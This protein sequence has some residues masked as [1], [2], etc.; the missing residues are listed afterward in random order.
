MKVLVI[1]AGSSSIKYELF[2]MDRQIRL[3]QG[4]VGRIGE[5]ESSLSYKAEGKEYKSNVSSLDYTKGLRLAM[6]MLVHPDHGVMDGLEEISAVGHRVVH[7]GEK[8]GESVLITQDVE[9]AIEE[10][11]SLAPLHNPPNLTCIRACKSLLPD[12]PHVAVFDTACHQS[13]PEHAYIYAIPYEL[14]EAH[15]IRRYGFHGTS[16]RYVANRAAKMLDQPLYSLKM[17]TCHLGNG[18][19]VTAVRDGRSVDTS[20]GF[21]PL[22]GLVMGTRSGDIDPAIV[23]YL[24]EDLNMKIAEIDDLL[25][26][27]SGLLGISGIS[28]DV[29]DISK[30]AAQGNKRAELALKVFS[31]RVRKYIG[32]Y[33]AAMGGIDVVVFTGGIGENA[34]NVREMICGE[35]G[36]L[37]LKLNFEK[38]RVASSREEVISQ[39]DSKVKVLVIRTDE[40]WLIAQ[41]TFDLV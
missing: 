28:N 5:E 16:H 21:T 32:A 31:Y 40:E 8:F 11:F 20:M 27:R 15:S 14:Y 22:E 7:G 12:V 30:A 6:E 35:L 39:R 24:Y 10:H 33:T 23:F 3:A 41:D 34:S 13:M 25:N 1:N 38:N 2:D 17:V 36:F 37:G 19:S 4:R 29:R 26:R 9:S 18:C